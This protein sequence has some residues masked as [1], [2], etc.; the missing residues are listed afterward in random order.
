[1]WAKRRN[2]IDKPK[3]LAGTMVRNRARKRPQ[4]IASKSKGEPGTRPSAKQAF[5]Q[6]LFQSPRNLAAFLSLSFFIA[7]ELP[8]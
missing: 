5:H 3:K 6:C 4:T 2:W 1:M 7:S 8:K